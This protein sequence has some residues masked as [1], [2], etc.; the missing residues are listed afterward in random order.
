MIDPDR[1]R[2]FWVESQAGVHDTDDDEG[3]D[4]DM[5]YETRTGK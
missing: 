1:E 2:I 4:P 3:P 5:I